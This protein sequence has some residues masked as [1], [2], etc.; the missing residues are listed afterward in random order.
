MTSK[1]HF[2]Y[3]SE[4]LKKELQNQVANH[5]RVVILTDSQ[6]AE[7]CLDLFVPLFPEPSQVEIIEI[8]PGESSKSPEILLELMGA[9]LDIPLDRNAL[10]V[11]FGGGVV[12]DIGGFAASIYKRGIPF[13]NVP[14]SLMGMCDASI[15]G[16]T[17]ID[18]AH[19]KNV[20]GAFAEPKSILIYPPF[21]HSLPKV[22][23]LSGFAE[24]VK[25]A[26]I[27]DNRLFGA[28]ET[29]DPSNPDHLSLFIERSASIKLEIVEKDYLE[30]GLR[31]VLN[32]GH[33]VGHAI[34]S[35]FLEIEKPITH[36]HA[37]ALGMRVE[38]YISFYRGR[39]KID[40]LG[41][42]KNL[43]TQ[44]YPLPQKIYWEDIVRFVLQDKKNKNG[45]ILISIPESIGSCMWD[46]Q[47]TEE[48]LRSAIE[49]ELNV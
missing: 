43:L 45:Q 1:L 31:K 36:G 9:F 30:K 25:H 21:I 49:E 26:I 46:V 2:H 5:S 23:L 32:F 42:I 22:E 16:K 38:A 44:A 8:E 14:T 48:E 12:T 3:S 6:V 33:T 10:L 13:L 4:S 29:I 47:V 15:G 18:F 34:E 19:Y 17:G 7:F 28:L 41:R 24:M 20:L 39:L 11:N 40:E 35:Y 37:V 27:A